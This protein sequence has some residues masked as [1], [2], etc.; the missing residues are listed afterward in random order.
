MNLSSLN[1]PFIKDNG[2]SHE[3]RHISCFRNAPYSG[4]LG[5]FLLAG[6]KAENALSNLAT[7]VYKNICS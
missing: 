3:E 4:I 2:P 1:I 6:L 7:Q 5:K